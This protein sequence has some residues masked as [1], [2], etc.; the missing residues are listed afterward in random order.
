[1]SWL[2]LT[3]V[4]HLVSLRLRR[5]LFRNVRF[6]FLIIPLPLPPSFPPFLSSASSF[7]ICFLSNSILALFPL[8]PVDVVD[9]LVK[10]LDEPKS[11][12]LADNA[13][14]ALRPGIKDFIAA[15]RESVKDPSNRKLYLSFPPLSHSLFLSPLLS[16]PLFSHPLAWIRPPMS[17]RDSRSPL[18]TSRKLSIPLLATES[19][20]ALVLPSREPLK[21]YVVLSHPSFFPSPSPL[22]SFLLFVPSSPCQLRKANESGDPKAIREALQ[23]L[24]D[25][26]A[27]YNGLINGQVDNLED[28]GR[29]KILD[30]EKKGA[31]ALEKDVARADPLDSRNINRILDAVP[32]TVDDY[33]N[34]MRNDKKDDAIKGAA[35][36][37]HLAAGMGDLDGDDMDLGD[38]LGTAGTLSSLLR[39]MVNHSGELADELGTDESKLTDAAKAAIAFDR[40]LRKLEGLEDDTEEEA[41]SLPPP[42]PP[43]PA[44]DT[45]VSDDMFTKGDIDSADT[46]EDLMSAVAYQIHNQAKSVSAEAD[47]IALA[48]QRLATAAREGKKQE[49]LLAA[50]EVAAHISTLSFSLLVAFITSLTLSDAFCKELAALGKSIPQ[51]NRHQMQEAVLSLSPPSLDPFLSLNLNLSL[52]L[53]SHIF[54]TPGSPHSCL[55]RPPHLR[56]SIEDSHIS[57]GRLHRGEP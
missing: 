35:L 55:S 34:A 13:M 38:L 50:R 7:L 17:W 27:Y 24:K 8:T 3:W 2:P 19:S 20:K 54:L 11:R 43:A 49:M 41:V 5:I 51:K 45:G 48:L 25:A 36:A 47:A 39:G 26:L 15:A 10:T 52:S 16:S 56:H 31:A 30:H 37:N 18:P 32:S 29:K 14:A 23:N 53:L 33:L 42:A 44:L 6:F 1:M 28:P 21:L 22:L 46:V 57:Q 40:S 12:Q 4:M 9:K